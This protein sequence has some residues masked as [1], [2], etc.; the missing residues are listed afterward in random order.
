MRSRGLS[1]HVGGSD[2]SITEPHFHILLHGFCCI[3]L[4]LGQIFYINS[5]FWTLFEL[6]FC[7]DIFAEKIMNFFIVNLN[8]TASNQMSF[9]II[10][11]C[12]CHY[13]AEG[14]WNDTFSFL[15]TR[16][17]HSVCFSAASL[18]ICKNSHIKPFRYFTNRG[19]KLFKNL[20]LRSLLTKSIIKFCLQN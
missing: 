19:Y 9:R 12:Y 18:P 2:C 4:Y 7:F 1:I 15:S 11:L 14:S 20:S 5:S 16:S 13:L 10:A 3:N 17:H 6:H 8:K